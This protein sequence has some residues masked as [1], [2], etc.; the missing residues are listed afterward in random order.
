M[1]SFNVSQKITFG[2]TWGIFFMQSIVFLS[3]SVLEDKQYIKV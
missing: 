2:K 1:L 3:V